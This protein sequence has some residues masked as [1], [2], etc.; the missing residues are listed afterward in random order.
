MCHVRRHGFGFQRDGIHNGLY[1]RSRFYVT[2][3][4][5]VPIRGCYHGPYLSSFG[6]HN[7]DM[8][9]GCPVFSN[10]IQKLFVN[11]SLK[12]QVYRYS[13]I[14]SINR[15]HVFH[16]FW[17]YFECSIDLNLQ[18]PSFFPPQNIVKVSFNTVFSLSIDYRSN[19]HS[20]TE[21]VDLAS[22]VLQGY[23]D[24][25]EEIYRDLPQY[26]VSFLTLT[27]FDNFSIQNVVY[28]QV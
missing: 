25:G 23:I 10:M 12:I 13:H 5:V 11:R 24:I 17:L 1:G 8:T 3:D 26:V 9:A 22:S 15:W 2:H 14:F 4:D 21:F 7:Y 27:E 19:D 6:F 16:N 28:F 18:L 20:H